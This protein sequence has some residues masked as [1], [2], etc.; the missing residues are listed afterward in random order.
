MNAPSRRADIGSSPFLDALR[1]QHGVDGAGN[2]PTKRPRS[3]GRRCVTGPGQ[4][5]E[6]V[7]PVRLRSD[8]A[9][10]RITGDR[11]R[12]GTRR[13]IRC[14]QIGIAALVSISGL[15]VDDDHRRRDRSRH[16]NRPEMSRAPISGNGAVVGAGQAYSVSAPLGSSRSSGGRVM[17]G[18]SRA[19]RTEPVNFVDRRF[20]RCYDISAVE[21]E[22]D[23]PCR[24][25]TRPKARHSRT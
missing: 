10:A 20:G 17:D 13:R 7:L 19:G 3:G 1:N 9:A 24:N 4:E 5:G 16:L 15:P 21:F 23:D 14:S 18:S 11:E 12:R 25:E 22:R 2:T 8:P 6:V